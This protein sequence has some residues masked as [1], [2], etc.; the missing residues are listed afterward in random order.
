MF[1]GEYLN[2]YRYKGKE[3]Y[4]NGKLKF[5]GEYLFAEKWNGKEYDYNGNVVFELINGNAIV[6]DEYDKI[7]IYIGENLKQK[8]LKGN[9]KGKEYDYEGRLLFEGEYLNE[10]RW[11]GKFYEYYKN[12]LTFEGEYLDG[13]NGVGKERS[14][15]LKVILHLKENI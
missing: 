1:D 11:K 15:I 9:V 5:E 7:K 12:E 8:K 10:R 6:E 4:T 3:Y 14:M 13:K 2:N